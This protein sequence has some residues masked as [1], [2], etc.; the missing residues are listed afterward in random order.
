[1]VKITKPCTICETATDKFCSGCKKVYYC[2][3]EHQKSHRKVHKKDCFPAELKENSQF[4]GRCFLASRAIKQGE[5]IFTDKA[6]L[7]GPSGA[8]N[9]FHPICLGCYRQVKGEGSKVYKCSTCGWPVCSKQCEDVRSQNIHVIRRMRRITQLIAPLLFQNAQHSQFECRIFS[10]N[11]IQPYFTKPV[12]YELINTL[13]SLLL[14]LIEPEKWKELAQLESHSEARAKNPGS[15]RAV[16]EH[17]HF[18]HSVCNLTV[19][20]ET[21]LIDHV[22]GV[23]G[24]NSFGAN[25]PAGPNPGRARYANFVKMLNAKVTICR[26]GRNFK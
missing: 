8:E 15:V 18:I 13:R 25:P 16:K 24:I 23:W 19:Q 21:R 14:M 22:V 26:H 11:Q 20:F 2:T 17:V 7:T 3:V 10:S 9:F 1:M 5:L 12:Q 4:G 6:L